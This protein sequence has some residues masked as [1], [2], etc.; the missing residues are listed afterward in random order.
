[1]SPPRFTLSSDHLQHEIREKDIMINQLIETR[2]QLDLTITHQ[3]D[4]LKDL[5]AMIEHKD[6]MLAQKDAQLDSLNA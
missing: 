1:V 3:K 5:R 6:A 2:H 4:E